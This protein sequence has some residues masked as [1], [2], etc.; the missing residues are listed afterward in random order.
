VYAV[1]HPRLTREG[2]WLA[3]VL[4]SGPGAVLSHLDAAVLWGIHGW[5][6]SKID[7]TTARRSREGS[8]GIRL[9]RVRRLDGE[10][11]TVRDGIP[12]TTVARTLID[13]TDVLGRDRL[14][15]LVREGEFMRLLDLDALDACLSRAHGRRRLGVL[16]AVLQ[17][18]RP[19]TI[20]RSEFEHRFLELCSEAGLPAPET[21]VRM[22]VRGRRYEF[23]CLW[24]EPGVIVELDGR[25]AHDNP[26]AFE[27]DRARDAALI[28]AGLRPLRYTWRR[29]SDDRTSVLAELRQV[30]SPARP[31]AAAPAAGSPATTR[32]SSPSRSS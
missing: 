23:D 16:R 25:P 19:G 29:M 30:L 4:A 13:L 3:A 7:V 26:R 12:V 9:H 21:N 17:Q 1:G 10:E 28:A 24:R 11:V 20:V 32:R 15:R 27:I 18:H 6:T 2:Q 8:E 14:T 31:P 22:K 5:T